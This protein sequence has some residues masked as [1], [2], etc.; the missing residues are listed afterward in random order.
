VSSSFHLDGFWTNGGKGMTKPENTDELLTYRGLGVFLLTD[1]ILLQI[2]VHLT[3]ADSI[4]VF[5]WS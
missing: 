5:Q 4:Q 1:P 3:C 2:Q